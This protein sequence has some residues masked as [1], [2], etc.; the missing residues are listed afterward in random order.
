MRLPPLLAA[1]LLA[2]GLL[3]VPAHGGLVDEPGVTPVARPGTAAAAKRAFSY[4]VL[5]E[6]LAAAMRSAGGRSGAWVADLDAGTERILFTDD[7]HERRFSA[8]RFRATSP[9]TRRPFSRS[10]GVRPDGALVTS[11]RRTV[12]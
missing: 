10:A 3:A 5:R 11:V 9:A 6:E 1:A 2:L 4:G 7:A 12:G 8:P